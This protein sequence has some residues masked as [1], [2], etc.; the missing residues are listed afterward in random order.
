MKKLFKLTQISKFRKYDGIGKISTK[1][2]SINVGYELFLGREAFFSPEI[3]DK[4]WRS[5]LDETID[6]TI[7]QCSIDYRNI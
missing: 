7:Q 4:N 3:I 6:L 2:F 5:S 1:P